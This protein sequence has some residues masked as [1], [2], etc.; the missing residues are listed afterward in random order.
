MRLSPSRPLYVSLIVLCL[1]LVGVARP[2]LAQ[3]QLEGT[4]L[5]AWGD[6]H[7]TLGGASEVRYTLA[8]PDGR[9]V[10]LDVTGREALA[11]ASFGR[12]VVL[13]GRP[14][15]SAAPAVIGAAPVEATFAVEAILP[16]SDPASALAEPGAVAFGTRKVVFVLAK[17]PD[18][19]AVPHSATFFTDLT[20]PLT[21]PGGATFPATIN[22]FF[23]KTSWN[24]FSWIGDAAGVGGLGAPGGWMTLP[25]P[26]S[27]YANCGWS[28]SCFNFSALSTD[29][30]TLAKA[31]G[32]SFTDYD[33]INF[34]VS[35]DLDCCA[36]GGGYYMDGKSYGATWEPPW[37]QETGTY[38]H[39]MGHSI[40]LPHSGWVYY[41]Y[42]SPWD[43][44][45]LRRSASSIACGSYLSINSSGSTS[46]IGCTEP[47]DG[48]I[49]AHKDYL[50]WIP[51]A[52]VLVTDTYSSSSVTLDGLS[53][54]LSTPLKL[55]KICLPTFSCTG[56]MARFLT[57]EARVKALGTNSQ[58]D[59][60][61]YNEGI[62]IHDVR[63]DR[64]AISGSCYFNSQSGWA[65][66]VDSTPGDY[67]ST[68]CASSGALTNAQFGVGQTYTNATYGVS[69]SVISRSG[70]T[71][72]VSINSLSQEWIQNGSFAGGTSNWQVYA[73][74]DN[75]YLTTN[76]TGGVLQFSRTP[77]PAGAANQG[78]VFQTTGVAVGAS[79]AVTAQFDLG[80]TST[81]RKRVTVLLLDSNFADLAVCSFWLPPSAPLRTFQMKAHSTN[82]WSNAAIYFYAATANVNGDTGFYQVDN[83]SVHA[84]Q[85]QSTA[86]TDCI[87]PV[88]P[89]AP[90][91]ASSANLMTNGDFASGVVAPWF[92][93]G[94]I[95]S[96]VSAGVFE[97][98]RPAGTPA[99]VI[100][101]STGQ[102]VP[103][104]EI[105][106]STFQ[107]GN[108][109]NVRKRVTVLLH[110]SSF[111][112][113]TACTFWLPAFS[114]LQ[115]YT[116]RAYASRAWTNATLS[117]YPATVGA[118]QWIRLDTVSLLRTPSVTI[119][120]TSCVEPG[121]GS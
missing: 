5:V 68:T 35:N 33:N 21:P 88:T 42:D 101:Q 51:P 113:L 12:R 27:Y 11:V 70:S 87:D 34:V 41:A 81:V 78:T 99:G 59:N 100:A 106:S 120:G 103:V 43:M 86:R 93:Y 17:F 9:M 75:S 117:V 94:Q 108:S 90:G 119:Q 105:V 45:S 69:V 46:T 62:V 19:A 102:A 22:G 10:P 97:F 73:T 37:G 104:S 54:G 7:P 29:A 83:V 114:G 49:S 118:E 44:M 38:A 77:G 85:S 23:S 48:Y 31:E 6:P 98:V 55:V 96:R 25:H 3:E 82:A 52:N 64:P 16:L 112:D 39:E 58:F 2:A 80:N 26:K 95:T 32:V 56:G 79:A 107:L 121:G 53:L 13:T 111:D 110:D 36:W 1:A 30:V 91:G 28:T 66:P 8:L 50:G 14:Q 60:A 92:L 65:V 76:V 89:A 115:T 57:V 63:M 74:P 40:G 4:L 61:I 109:S 18:D 20:N 47:G 24:Q 15:A 72:V 116:M 71:F 84:G 67:N